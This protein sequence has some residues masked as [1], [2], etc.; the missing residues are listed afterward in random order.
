LID[1]GGLEGQRIRRHRKV[2]IGALKAFQQGEE[3]F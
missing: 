1:N 3:E 2:G